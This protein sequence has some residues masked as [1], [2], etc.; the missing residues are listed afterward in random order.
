MQSSAPPQPP[1]LAPGTLLLDRYFIQ[2]YIGGGGFGHIYRAQDKVLGHRRAIKEAFYRDPNTQ[3]QFHFE[4]E[5]LINARHPNLVQGYALFEQAGR[6]YLV[7]DYVDG[8]TLE[9]ITIQHIRRTGFPLVET[10]ILDWLIPICDAVWSLHQQPTPIIHRDIKPAN[11]KLN[12]QGVPVL[13]DL[14]LAKLYYRGSQTIGAALAFTPG[15]APP[16]QYQASGATDQRTDVYGMGATLYYLLTGY[17]PT[18]SPARLSSNTLPPPRQLN[19][20]LSQPT[21]AAIL[22]A[23]SLDPTARQQSMSSLM[24]ELRSARSLLITGK[25]PV[26]KIDDERRIPCTRCGTANVLAARFCM[27]CGN[28]IRVDLPPLTEDTYGPEVLHLVNG[29]ES[30]LQST[31]EQPEMKEPLQQTPMATPASPPL[32]SHA[33]MLPLPSAYATLPAALS[34]RLLQRPPADSEEA[35]VVLA[36]VL[37]AIAFALSLLAAIAGWLLIFLAPAFG[38]AG[39]SCWQWWQNPDKAPPEFKWLSIG[40]AALSAIWTTLYFL[41]FHLAR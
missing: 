26:L 35:L 23:M 36:S 15:Y 29:V 37:A 19:P 34:E 41:T 39:W 9:D 5:F 18:E 25:M 6:L 10:Q 4:A 24:A 12:R 32:E 3:R 17:Q 1:A 14:G 38:L 11:I 27:R 13:I 2:G 31:L 33:R 30:P 8:Y 40:I 21:E 20:A 22:K 7:M 16:E 28:P